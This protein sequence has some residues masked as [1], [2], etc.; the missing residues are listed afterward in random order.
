[1]VISRPTTP[2]LRRMAEDVISQAQFDR[3][4]ART[5]ISEA[6][7]TVAAK[8]LDDATLLAPFSGRVAAIYVENFENVEAKQLVLRLLDISQ[9]EMILQVPESL[10]GSSPLP[11]GRPRS[12]SIPF[13]DLAIPASVKEISNEASETTRTYPVTLVMTPPAEGVEILAG[14]A[15]EATGRA[16]LARGCPRKPASR[17]RLRPSSADD[18]SQSDQ[19]YVWTVDEASHTVNRQTR[20]DES[21]SVSPRRLRERPRGR[22]PN[23]HRRCAL[24][25]ARG[26]PCGS[27]TEAV[28]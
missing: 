17:C 22:Q 4:A 20:R 9:V 7:V 21:P 16:E 24:A 23:R 13:P 3:V 28:P 12:A 1:M 10:I 15:G 8:A 11:A 5:E 27:K 25:S 26:R 19:S 6:K 18:A 14:M 2:W